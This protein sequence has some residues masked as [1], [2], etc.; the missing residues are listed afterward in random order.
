MNI[1]INTSL[2]G[3]E[4]NNHKIIN[5]GINPFLAGCVII[6]NIGIDTTLAWPVCTTNIG[7][8]THFG[9][10]CNYY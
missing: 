2:V 9:W 10:P 8:K 6:I 4:K 5:I 7:K 1:K 3:P